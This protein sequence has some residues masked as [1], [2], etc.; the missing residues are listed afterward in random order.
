[1]MV[2]LRK[3]GTGKVLKCERCNEERWISIESK[4][5]EEGDW[6]QTLECIECGFEIRV[7]EENIN[8][9]II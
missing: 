6:I 4:E 2:I 3:S 1:M 7:S 5:N 9:I 8:T